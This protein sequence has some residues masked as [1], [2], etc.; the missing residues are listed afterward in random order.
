MLA[1]LAHFHCPVRIDQQGTPHCHQIKLAVAQPLQQI[2][3][4]GRLRDLVGI[5]HELQE[6]AVQPDTTDGNGRLAGQLARPARQVQV[7]AFKLRLPETPGRAVE[8]VHASVSQRLQE[9]TQRFRCLHQPRSVVLLFPLRE[10]E[11]DRVVRSHCDTHGL[12]QLDGKPRT[13]GEAAAVFVSA[14][15]AAFPEEL[16]NQITMG[17]MDFDAVHANRLGIGG[18]LGKGS[19]NIVD[20]LPVHAMHQHLTV[21][22]LLHRPVGRHA[23]VR[24][25]TG[26]AHCAYMPEL[27]DDPAALRMHRLNHLAPTGQRRVTKKLR[28]VWIAIGSLVIDRCA[29]GNDKAYTCR[30]TTPVILDNLRVGH[31]PRR[32]RTGHRRHDYP[33]RQRQAAQAQRRKQGFYRHAELRT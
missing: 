14:L 13:V 24:L 8:D 15:V 10:T 1:S 31:M 11:N 32:E 22:D 9:F 7:G 25:G 30:R 3:Q 16:I 27:R 2:L 6:L 18:G 4:T 20:V 5:D 19:H 12:D 33:R 28:N 29:F 21:L 26:T 23:C 17:P